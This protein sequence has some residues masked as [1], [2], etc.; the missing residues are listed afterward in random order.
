M[1]TEIP[2]KICTPNWSN[3]LGLRIVRS[4][5]EWRKARWPTIRARSWDEVH[6]LVRRTT[7]PPSSQ[8]EFLF[9]FRGG[10]QDRG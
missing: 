6:A 4:F 10:L 7:T 9:P 2:M 5:E 8:R 1:P 3:P